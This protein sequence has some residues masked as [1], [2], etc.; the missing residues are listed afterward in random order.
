MNWPRGKF[1]FT[2]FDDTDWCT[3][4]AAR[5]VYDFL[6][7][8]GFRTTKSL[9]VRPA[10]P[11]QPAKCPGDTLTDDAYVQWHG[12]LEKRG[13]E[14][15]LHNISAATSTREQI[16]AGLNTFA[17]TFGHPP[18]CHTNHT[19]T[20]DAVYWG[21]DRLTGISRWVYNLLTRYKKAKRYQGHRTESPYYWG[22]LL[23]QQITYIRNFVFQETNT[24]AVCPEMP[25]YNPDTPMAN[26]WFA[27]CDGNDVSAF[28]RAI[29][30]SRQD[31][32]EAQ[33]GA[34]I[35]YTHF[36][37]SFVGADGTLHPE[38]VRLM[39][40]LAS[41]GGAYIPVGPLLDNLRAAR[42]GDMHISRARRCALS[43]KWLMQKIR[44]G[45]TR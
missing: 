35:M 19:G 41:K 45:G 16:Q 24:L 13:F 14:L 33:G 1:A 12:E 4:E 34:C 38:W 3:V 6:T 27:S 28:C 18:S 2:V 5:P 42:N 15:A 30:E 21:A 8:Q 25:Y 22:D 10:D 31:Q 39:K 23:Q 7:E 17:E 40:R 44:T 32:L 43:R 11:G 29:H 9:W 20:L 37:K 36:S 26:L